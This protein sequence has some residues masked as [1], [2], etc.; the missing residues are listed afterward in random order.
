M[1]RD[2][3]RPDGVKALGRKSAA[4]SA[5]AKQK[6]AECA[7]PV[8]TEAAFPPYVLRVTAAASTSAA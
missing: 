7:A 6:K 2:L 8:I 3:A 4:S 1:R 5:I